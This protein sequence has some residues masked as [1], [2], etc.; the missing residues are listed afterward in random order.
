MIESIAHS[1]DFETDITQLIEHKEPHPQAKEGE[2]L[3]MRRLE[4]NLSEL[5]PGRSVS[6]SVMISQSVSHDQSKDFGSNNKLCSK[7]HFVT[8]NVLQC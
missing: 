2:S 7:I 5:F 8:S 4:C 1:D 3:G 6:Q